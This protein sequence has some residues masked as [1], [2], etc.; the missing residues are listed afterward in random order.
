MCIRDS[1]VDSINKS[2]SIVTE[3]KVRHIL[4]TP[5][6]MTS[7]EIVKDKLLN[8][9]NKIKDMDEFILNAK[10]YSDDKASGYKGGDL[11]YQ[12]PS[13]LVKEF[14]EVM[15]KTPLKKI[16]DPF[17]SRFGWH[18]LYEGIAKLV[19]PYWS[20]AGFLLDSKWI[21]SGLA[22]TIV[23][24]PTLLTIS[25]YGNMWG[26]TIIG[27]LLMTGL[28]NRY[29]SIAGM[30]LIL[31]YYYHQIKKPDFFFLKI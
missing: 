31:S 29:A 9:K 24:N 22:K 10:K 19:S 11:G 30:I 13:A 16:S 15:K 18:I 23:S 12:R 21:F 26:L 17:Q 1:I 3:Y 6:V 2:S 7:N 5:N 25:D 27:L 20:S 14:A 28:F 4:I 8:L